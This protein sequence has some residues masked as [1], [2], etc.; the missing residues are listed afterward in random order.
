MD[1]VGRAVLFFLPAGIANMAPVLAARMPVLKQWNA[2]I[3]G[4]TE[5]RGSRLFGANKTWRGLI[6]G[7]VIASL[8]GAVIH[9]F[10]L[11]DVPVWI[12]TLMGAGALMGDAIESF[13]KRQA[14]VKP[15]QSWF[16]FDQTDYIIGGLLTTLPFG[17][18]DGLQVAVILVIYFGLHLLLSYV[19]FLIGFKE[20][21][22]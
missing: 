14:G 5:Y 19:A 6:S 20:R 11:Y 1:E 15:G 4:G 13:F 22:M 10:A 16:P 3:D 2:P 12:Y 21:P 18:I 17:Y 9:R 8:V 7:V